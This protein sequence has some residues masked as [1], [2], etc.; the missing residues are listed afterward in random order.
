MAIEE[1]D[2]FEE[3]SNDIASLSDAFLSEAT[4]EE[5]AI[6]Q[7]EEGAFEKE[8]RALEVK[9]LRQDIT[10]RKKY[11]S[12][13]FWMVVAWLF[14]ILL[15]IFLLGFEIMELSQTVVVSLIGATT[16]NVTAFFLAVAKYLFPSNS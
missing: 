7:Y 14:I 13:I 1:K 4:G 15:I 9:S 5:K 8:K 11:A 3:Y 16:I 10:E 12:W 2:S 6:S